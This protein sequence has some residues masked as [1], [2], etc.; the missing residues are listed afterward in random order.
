[1]LKALPE[2]SREAVA[3]LAKTVDLKEGVSLFHSGERN[4]VIFPIDS[5]VTLFREFEDGTML[6]VAMIGPEGLVDVNTVLREP[7]T[8]YHWIVQSPGAAARLQ[9]GAFMT[10][11]DQDEALRLLMLKYVHVRVM[12]AAQLAA[13]NRLHVVTERLAFWLLLLHD[14]VPSDEMTVTQEFLARMLGTRRAGINVA[15]RELRD[16]GA[17]EHRRNRVIVSNRLVLEE[18]SCSCYDIMSEDYGR[19]LGFEA[20]PKE[21][22]AAQVAG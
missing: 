11:L 21:L 3:R 6:Q 10:L 5:V 17:I 12:H 19:S 14:R 16:A 18:Q 1:M 2:R 20:Q 4:D 13:C 22:R 8:P 15:M 7:V 9:A